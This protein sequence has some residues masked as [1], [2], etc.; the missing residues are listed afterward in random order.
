MLMR[1][2]LPCSSE[3]GAAIRAGTL[4]K[5]HKFEGEMVNYGDDLFDLQVEEVNFRKSDTEEDPSQIA[6]QAARYLRTIDSTGELEA[7][8]GTK[9]WTFFLRATSSDNGILRKHF[10][11]EGSHF[12]QG[13]VLALLSTSEHET[14]TDI[15]L[16][17]SPDSIF[18]TVANPF[19]PPSA[20]APADRH[21]KEDAA[22]ARP[23]KGSNFVII[24]PESIENRRI[25]LYTLGGRYLNWLFACAPLIRPL[26]TSTC[27]I[28]REGLCRGF[29]GPPSAR[30]DL[31][32]QSLHALPDGL[33]DVVDRMKLRWDDFHLGFFNS[34]FRVNCEEGE[35][36]FPKT[37]VLL[38]VVPDLVERLF[39]HRER[40]YLIAP[41]DWWF[42]ATRSLLEEEYS[43]ETVSWFAETFE[44]VG[45]LNV[46]QF[47][48]N[49][50]SMVRNLRN[51]A[52]AEVLVANAPATSS[53]RSIHNC[54]FVD[55]PENRRRLEF[56]LALVELSRK[57]DFC[58]LDVD[59][60]FKRA[61]IRHQV[62]WDVVAPGLYLRI[63]REAVGILQD[64]GVL[65]GR[66]PSERYAATLA[67]RLAPPSQA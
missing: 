7:T 33:T 49:L 62:G 40:G 18:R 63:A 17:S 43:P 3:L 66:V 44:C 32:L 54:A 39:R 64:L 50:A 26:L 1:L 38:S 19:D 51:R 6:Q 16:G 20:D 13:T 45:R 28:V 9:K 14:L 56:N 59:R 15:D 2:I 23:R 36:E 4:V 58:I 31:L 60:I 10:V 52:G 37:I 41:K 29:N 48:N 67:P 61:G 21:A 27:C 22:R 57:V 55:K 11:R 46:E 42:N 25:G 8:E 47:S 34:T 24:E 30:S 65:S 53:G 12:E 35:N 5:W